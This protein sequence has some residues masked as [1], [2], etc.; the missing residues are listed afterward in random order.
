MSAYNDLGELH[1]SL[2]QSGIMQ[3]A[4]TEGTLPDD[5][6]EQTIFSPRF[7]QRSI[8]STPHVSLSAELGA[9]NEEHPNISTDSIS[10]GASSFFLNQQADNDQCNTCTAEDNNA[11]D[12]E[13]DI[14][15]SMS[16]S[17]FSS[18][19]LSRSIFSFLHR[20]QMAGPTGRTM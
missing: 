18:S 16:T 1:P 4:S 11:Q 20:H 17:G 2:L 9:A 10:L 6:V 19:H 15:N 14:A 3:L 13:G 7:V 5:N 8:Q 12:D